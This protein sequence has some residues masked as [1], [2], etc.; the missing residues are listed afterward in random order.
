MLFGGSGVLNTDG[1]RIAFP[2][3]SPARLTDLHVSLLKA[4]GIDGAFGKD[5][6]VF[7]D[8]GTSPIDGVI[9]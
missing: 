3:E 8:D 4:Y 1:R 7:G 6:A 9:A 5:G 2:A